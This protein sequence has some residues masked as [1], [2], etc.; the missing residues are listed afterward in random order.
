MLHP[1]D[2][3]M[4]FDNAQIEAAV[5]WIAM[6]VVLLIPWLLLYP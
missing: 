5:L 4:T 6:M 3:S 2:Y 1:E